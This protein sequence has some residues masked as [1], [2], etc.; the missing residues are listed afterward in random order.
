[1]S[2][3]SATLKARI[4]LYDKHKDTTLREIVAIDHFSNTVPPSLVDQWLLALDPDPDRA[5]L[6]KLP[7]GIKGFYGG[8]LRASIPIELAHDCYKYI[9]YET[10]D[11]E[12]T[13][14]YAGR[15]L[16]AIGL[17][18]LE[19]LERE[20]V[21]LAGLALWH[22]ALALVR[23]VGVELVKVDPQTSAG[24]A[25]TGQD[26]FETLEQYA[27]I[28]ARSQLPDAKLPLPERLKARLLSTAHELGNE[29]ATELLK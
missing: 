5:H 1:M 11:R 6:F 3:M 27:R 20:D 15:M 25:Y 2:D 12:K 23:L 10:E 26:L 19:R 24:L 16:L 18:D 8:D 14:K 17:L 13:A 7:L 28:R 4:A 21:D 29:T 22:K 9:V